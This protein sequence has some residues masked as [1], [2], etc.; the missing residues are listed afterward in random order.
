MKYITSGGQTDRQ[1]DEG[2]T[3]RST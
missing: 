2:R 3:D 1:A